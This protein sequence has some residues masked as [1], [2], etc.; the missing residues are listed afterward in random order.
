MVFGPFCIWYDHMFYT[1]TPNSDT[2]VPRFNRIAESA[3]VSPD[4]E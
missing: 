3:E 4:V 1:G 2:I